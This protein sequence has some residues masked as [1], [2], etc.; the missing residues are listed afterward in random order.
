MLIFFFFFFFD[1]GFLLL[2]QSLT[3]DYL[4]HNK[5]LKT[6]TKNV[7]ILGQIPVQGNL[8]HI[9]PCFRSWEGLDKDGLEGNRE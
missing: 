7:T 5:P 8:S 9:F 4:K 2:T 6:K 1:A 3:G